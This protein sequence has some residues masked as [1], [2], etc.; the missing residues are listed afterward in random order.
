M[1]MPMDETERIVVN[2]P[3]NELDM[4]GITSRKNKISSFAEML[5]VKRRNSMPS[6]SD[7]KYNEGE[8]KK[9]E[10]FSG[11]ANRRR[12]K[13][14]RKMDSKFTPKK[15]CRQTFEHGQQFQ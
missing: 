9:K 15:I 13:G 6:R 12:G 7:L 8:E 10:F 1:E 5:Q 14:K 2:P 4:R 3:M 11:G